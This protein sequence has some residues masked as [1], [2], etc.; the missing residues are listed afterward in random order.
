MTR[1]NE[2]WRVIMSSVSRR[3]IAPSCSRLQERLNIVGCKPVRNIEP[4]RF[5]PRFVSAA[6]PLTQ[7]ESRAR[8]VHACPEIFVRFGRTAEE[9]VSRTIGTWSIHEREP[10]TNE[11]LVVTRTR[12]NTTGKLEAVDAR[13][14]RFSTI[15][16]LFSIVLGYLSM[17]ILDDYLVQV[18]EICRWTG[19]LALGCQRKMES[20]RLMWLN[21]VVCFESVCWM[22]FCWS[23]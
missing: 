8:R 4:T 20:L 23:V 16:R 12:V 21:V 19:Y 22:W 1:P 14:V 5:L 11:R 13:F 6:I 18:I 2:S 15:E 10:T 7:R 17:G 9:F 3:F